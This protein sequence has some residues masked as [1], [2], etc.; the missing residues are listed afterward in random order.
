MMLS[1][2]M[3]FFIEIISTLKEMKYRLKQSYHKKKS[4]PLLY[5]TPN[6]SFTLPYNIQPY[7][8]P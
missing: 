1:V 3:I 5:P 8:L 2:T 7:P 6:L 4:Y